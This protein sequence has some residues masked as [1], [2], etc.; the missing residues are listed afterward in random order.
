MTLKSLFPWQRLV[1]GTLL[2][3][4]AFVVSPAKAATEVPIFDIQAVLVTPTRISLGEPI[5]VRCDVAN[6][7]GRT[8]VVR[9]RGCATDWYT[10]S[11]RNANGV[12]MPPAP[13]APAIHSE[14]LRW[15]GDKTLLDGGTASEYIPVS[16]LKPLTQ[17]GKYEVSVRISLQYAIT[18]D[19]KSHTLVPQQAPQAQYM[20]FSVIVTP[21]DPAR[22]K[23]V[24]EQLRSSATSGNSTSQLSMG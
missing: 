16:K 4:L 7:S 6:I 3:S 18:S 19:P 10:V 23:A 12:D 5:M 20:R 1:K 15:V 14:D 11:M 17:A 22:L 9:M 13:N 21:H 2:F 24:A 8:A